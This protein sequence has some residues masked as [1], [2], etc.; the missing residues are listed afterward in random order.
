MQ[1]FFLSIA[2][3]ATDWRTPLYS[4]EQAFTFLAIR[5]LNTR[6]AR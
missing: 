5:A 1:R 4:H 3:P 2:M 6:R